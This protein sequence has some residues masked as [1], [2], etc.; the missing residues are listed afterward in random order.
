MFLYTD[1]VLFGFYIE[2]Q[3]LVFNTNYEAVL[4]FNPLAIFCGYSTQFVSDLVRN[5]KDRFSH[6]ETLYSQK[7]KAEEQ[8]GREEAHTIQISPMALNG[9]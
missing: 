6:E 8:R 7:C 9:R 4:N 2:S 1:H 5:P 3:I